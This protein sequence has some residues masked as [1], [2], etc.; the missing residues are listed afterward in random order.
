MRNFRD[1]IT[2]GAFTIH[3]SLDG[4]YEKI[5]GGFHFK[6]GKG[7]DAIPA[8]AILRIEPGKLVIKSDLCATYRI[9]WRK[10]YN[11]I[12]ISDSVFNFISEEE[13]SQY[14]IISEEQTYYE[15]HGYTTS[16]ETMFRGVH[17]LP[18][19]SRLE[20]T[21]DDIKLESTW[22]FARIS[23]NPDIGLFK[24]AIA[25]AVADTLLPLKDISRPV[26]LC[27]SGGVDS[28]YISKIMLKNGIKHTLLYILDHNLKSTLGGLKTAESK[29]KELGMHLEVVDVTGMVDDEIEKR[30]KQLNIFDR[31]YYRIHFYGLKEIKK[32]WGDEAVIVNGQNSDGI[33]SYGPSEK[34]ITSFFKRYLIYGKSRI[35]K[36]LFAKIIGVVFKRRFIVPDN[37][38]DYLRGFYDNFKYCL[39]N[40]SKSSTGETYNSYITDLVEKH[41]RSDNFTSCNNMLMYLKLHSYIQGADCQTVTQSAKYFNIDCLLPMCSYNFFLATLMYKDDRKELYHPKYA[42]E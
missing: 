7:G 22:P 27:F 28:T 34:K 35:V 38:S 8:N 6:L 1:T 36:I 40:Q 41:K 26:V 11:D 25:K 13:L 33:L 31:H 32:R 2:I 16:G 37:E 9:Y 14:E 10:D 4:G 42:L 30:I 18:P 15:R 12:Y 29:A 39:L 17:K 3:L 20:I 5:N 21:S 24:D 19:S 23:R